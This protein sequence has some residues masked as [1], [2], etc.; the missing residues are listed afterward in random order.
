M[1]LRVQLAGLGAKMV[2]QMVCEAFHGPRSAGHEA[3][4]INGDATDNRSTNLMWATPR[5]NQLHRI[6]YGK[7]RNMPFKL[8]EEDRK[9]IP[10]LRAEGMTLK[11]IAEIFAVSL[12]C[13]HYHLRKIPGFKSDGRHRAAGS[14]DDGPGRA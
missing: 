5:Q 7:T 3:A 10:Q 4:H 1:Y 14:P 2:H 8:S 11:Q 9:R 13:I 12:V 6:G